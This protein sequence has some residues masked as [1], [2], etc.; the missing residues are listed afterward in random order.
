MNAITAITVS[1][2]PVAAPPAELAQKLATFDGMDLV[3]GTVPAI[4]VQQARQYLAVLERYH[5]PANPARVEMWC[6]KLRGGT[7]PI[8]DRDFAQRLE[9]ITEDCAD[10]PAWVWSSDTLRIVRRSNE[11]FPTSKA[12]YDALSAISNRATLGVSQVR[13]LANA[14][15][16]PA[17]PP[18]TTAR[19]EQVE[20]MRHEL[21]LA[22]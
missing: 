6:Y 14:T 13:M 22:R 19:P 7:A 3:R 15:P 16:A 20:R 1:T 11:F 18:S 12:V 8:S 4:V 5:A 21:G 10:L 2:L 17:P 9:A